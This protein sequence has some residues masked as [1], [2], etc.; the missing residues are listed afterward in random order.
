MGV[1]AILIFAVELQKLPT[2]Y[3]F[4]SNFLK[5]DWGEFQNGMYWKREESVKK[6]IFTEFTSKSQI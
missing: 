6:S 2:K 1:M 3:I 4:F 5:E